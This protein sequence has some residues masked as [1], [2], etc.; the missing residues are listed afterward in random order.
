MIYLMPVYEALYTKVL[1]SP[2][3]AI[4]TA[5]LIMPSKLSLLNRTIPVIKLM[6]LQAVALAVPSRQLHMRG[7]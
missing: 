3:C 1:I 7:R 6:A 5:N 4:V 2:D